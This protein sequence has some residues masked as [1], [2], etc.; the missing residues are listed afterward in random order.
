MMRNTNFSAVRSRRLRTFAIA[1]SVVLVAVA[2]GCGSNSAPAD[3]APATG[4]WDKVVAAAKDEG[5]LH[6][7]SGLFSPDMDAVMAAFN[8]QYG[9]DAD[10]EKVQAE[11]VDR[12]T[13]EFNNKVY[14]WDVAFLNKED[15]VAF[16]AKGVVTK[17]DGLDALPNWPAGAKSDYS[18]V[19]GY[20]MY[21]ISWNVDKAAPGTELTS[22]EDLLKPEYKG[23]VCGPDPKANILFAYNYLAAEKASGDPDYLTKLK[24]NG[25]K[26]QPGFSESAQAIAAGECTVGMSPQVTNNN[27]I[28]QGAPIKQAFPKGSTGVERQ[29]AIAAHAPDPNAARLF[30]N[31]LMTPEGQEALNGQSGVSSILSGVQGSVPLVDGYLPYDQSVAKQNLDRI[32]KALGA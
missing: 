7:Y 26:L 3:S 11:A 8:K 23:K 30:V 19:V 32:V 10:Y 17:I 4:G 25:L 13:E 16:A 18:I 2:A 12:I 28:K 14:S 29:V 9:I 20:S 31:F 21:G 22:Y 15:I 1:C 24:A 27:L 5:R 6:A